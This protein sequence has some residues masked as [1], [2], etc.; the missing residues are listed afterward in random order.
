[1]R[2]S[3]KYI[4]IDRDLFTRLINKHGAPALGAAVGRSKGWIQDQLVNGYMDSSMVEAI[5]E[6]YGID[7][8]YSEPEIMEEP[9]PIEEPKQPE[10]VVNVDMRGLENRIDKI[11]RYVNNMD[12]TLVM[13]LD[14]MQK[15]EKR[16]KN[17]P[18]AR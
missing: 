7:I 2:S 8:S 1:M 17:K 18:Y 5:H 10:P 11:E 9:K 6:R 14:I 12:A 16:M 3:G 13:M 15:Q 4:Q